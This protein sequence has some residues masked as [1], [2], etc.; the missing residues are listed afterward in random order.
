MRQI[1]VLEEVL[2]GCGTEIFA[3]LRRFWSVMCFLVV[4]VSQIGVESSSCS[5]SSSAPARRLSLEVASAASVDLICFRRALEAFNVYR[6]VSMRLHSF[7]G[8]WK[9]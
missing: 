5:S 2:S 6:V 7:L 9:Y 4:R 1:V 8:F 3:G